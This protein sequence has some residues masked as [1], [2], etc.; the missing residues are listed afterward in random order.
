MCKTYDSY[1]LLSVRLTEN[2]RFK[3]KGSGP[4][5]QNNKEVKEELMADTELVGTTHVTTLFMHENGTHG[6]DHDDV[7][8]A[9][10]RAL[11]SGVSSPGGGYGDAQPATRVESY[12]TEHKLVFGVQRKRLFLDLTECSC[13]V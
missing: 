12:K 10:Q 4:S 9:S 2:Q 5:E 7:V 13:G 3:F 11:A 1:S 6:H 8:P